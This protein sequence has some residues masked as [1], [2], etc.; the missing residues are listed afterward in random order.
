MHIY[1]AHAAEKLGFNTVKKAV[2]TYI[3][4]EMGA[5]EL[6]DL[7]PLTQPRHIQQQLQRLQ[8]MLDLVQAEGQIPFEDMHDIRA[9]ARRS[10]VGRSILDAESMYRI[11]SFA[12]SS[13][14]LKN[15]LKSRHETHPVLAEMSTALIPMKELEKS[16]S[17]VITEHGRVKDSASPALQQI[18]KSINSRKNEL[19]TA[20][21]R[22]I[23]NLSKDNLLAEFEATI[24]N[25]RM[26]VPVR[27]ENKRRVNGF[28]QDVSATG[29]TVYIEPAEA[30]HINNDIRELEKKESQELERILMALTAEIGG[31]HEYLLT[32]AEVI[33]RMDLLIAKAL[34][35]RKL[36]AF[37][38][39]IKPGGPMHLV[40]AKNPALMLKN[41]AL[42]KEQREDVVPLDLTLEPEEKGV[43]ITGPNAGGK[44]V[45]LKTVA[46]LQM[47]LQSGFAVP[48][49]ESSVFPLYSA[50]FLDMGDEQSID[51]D[52][53]TFSSRLTWMR[54][55]A[56]MADSES[57]ILVDEAGTGTD[58]EEGVALFQAFLE[59]MYARGAMQIATTHHGHLK[60]FAHNHEGFVNA[61]M[62]FDSVG[63]SPTYHFQKGL[64]GS[65]YAFE[66]G[67]RLGLSPKLLSRAKDLVGDSKNRLESLILD[68]EAKAQ[69]ASDLKMDVYKEKVKA[70]KLMK[71]YEKRLSTLTT[72]RDKLREKALNDAQEIMQS[73]NARIEEAIQQIYES[74]GDKEKI[75]E[76]RK[77]VDAHRGKV[78]EDLEKTNARRTGKN[79][80]KSDK[81]PKQG[82]T[83]RFLDSNT[84]G[85]LLEVNGKQAVVQVNGLRLKTK[86][87]N[88]EAAEESEKNKAQKGI[89]LTT[90]LQGE[91]QGYVPQAVS[92][93]LD[94]R[95]Y[96]GP[97]AVKA[98][99]QRLDQAGSSSL[100]KLEI[101]HG[102]GDGIL[103]KLVHEELQKRK[104]VRSFDLAPWQEGGPGCT[105]AE[106]A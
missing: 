67:K 73:A 98:L 90:N 45:S 74:G 16:I 70:E 47:M 39:E 11:G 60:V 15:F 100:N 21:N 1:P 82:D 93:R 76:I 94:L 87:K 46:L 6:E 62:E 79:R 102:K 51:N 54:E 75:K 101:I 59:L 43:I 53:S 104:E 66:I 72:E 69:E 37:I 103:K 106:L 96:R 57:L 23:R 55:T 92:P 35:C 5:E 2:H 44:S 83:V 42:P 97:D 20:L 80:K 91:D 38:P 56:K 63:L 64:P 9:A 71:E 86:Y 81:P 29:Q 52:L 12:A 28:V 77:G 31:Q 88:L 25:G 8:E 26:V 18:R 17:R 68:M 3:R 84:I 14:A 19:R 40:K 13:R 85:E 10:R 7:Q 30:L 34:F 95:G 48:A 99:N 22:I 61:S 32:N 50:I 36:E 89:T 58:P 78:A 105:I 24:R 27:A 49:D 33:G 4:S 41:N 65:S